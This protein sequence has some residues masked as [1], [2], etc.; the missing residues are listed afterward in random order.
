MN[1]KKGNTA[2]TIKYYYEKI[3]TKL[4]LFSVLYVTMKLTK[5]SH[6]Q[7]IRRPAT[8]AAKSVK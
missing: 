4:I 8:V 7:N 1:E 3:N 5:P 6:G 2:F